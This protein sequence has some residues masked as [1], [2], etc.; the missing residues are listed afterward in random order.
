MALDVSRVRRLLRSFDFSRLFAEELG[1]DRYTSSLSVTVDGRD[2]SLEAVAEK[3]GL[4]AFECQSPAEDGVP[5]YAVRRKI[6]RQV[7]KS[8]HEHILIFTDAGRTTQTWQW[9]K[10]EPGRPAQC[11]EHTYY[12]GQ[13]GDSLIQK[14][15]A[16]Q[17]LFEEEE[18]LTVVDVAG[19]TRAAFDVDRV[20]RRFY[21]RFKTEHA[22]FLKFIKGIPSNDD[23]EWYASLM[24]NR[25][26]FI[27][28][29]QKK[30]FLD[31]DRDYLRNRLRRMRQT[32]GNDKFLSFYRHFLLRLFHEGLGSRNRNAE[33][34]ELLGNV[35]FLNGGLFDV[36][37]LE[38]HNP[39]IAIPD[40]AFERLFDFF[41]AYQWH[42]DERPL[43]KDDEINP[44]VLGYIFEKYVNQKQ[45]GAYYTKEDIT[46]YIAKNTII[47]FL[48]DAAEKRCPIAF[49]P[50]S[51]VWQLLRD[52]PDR[53]IYAAVRK[54]VIDADGKLIPLPD[55]IAAGVSDVSKRTGWN[56]PA[57]ADY[58]LPTETWREHVARRNRCLEIREKLRAGEV[59]SINDLVTLNLDI[60]QFAQDAIENCEGP[61]LLRAFYHSIA[62]RMPRKSNET[63]EPGISVLDPTCGSGAFL[64]AALNI[65]EPLYEACLSRMQA[66]V[67]E[68]EESRPLTMEEQIRKIIADRESATVELKSTLVGDGPK[69]QQKTIATL[70]A[71]ANTKGGILLIGVEDD[72]TVCGLAHDYKALEKQ[73]NRDGFE[74]CLMNMLTDRLGR[75]ASSLVDVVFGQLGGCEVCRV[76]VQPSPTEVYFRDGGS[77]DLFIRAGNSTRK[78]KTSEAVK[79][80]Q[81]RFEGQVPPE[82]T[83]QAVATRRPAAKFQDFRDVLARVA[84]H[85]NQRYFI[86]KSIIIGNLFGVDIMEEAVEICK[87]RLFLKL[88]AQVERVGQIEPLPDIDFNIRA[89]NT[90]VGFTSLGEIEHAMT[91]DARGNMRFVTS[92]DQAALETIRERADIANRAYQQFR[93]QQTELG[94]AV[95]PEDKQ[96]LRRRLTELGEE[97]DEYMACQYGID[98]ADET[99]FEN[100]RKSHQPFHWL[101][102]FYGAMNDGGFDIVIGNPPWIE[103]ASV[104]RV[105]TVRH[106]RTEGCGNLHAL[107]TERSLQLRGPKGRMSFIVQLPLVSSTRMVSVRNVLR[108][109]ST[110]L[111]VVPFDDRPGKLF[112]GLQHCRAV[113]FLTEALNSSP[114]RLVATTRYQRWYTQV[115]KHVFPLIEF[116]EL[117]GQ[118]I[119]PALFPKYASGVEE[120][121]FRKV[122][123]RADITVGE[124]VRRVETPHYIFYQEATQYWVKATIG[125]PYYAKNGVVGPPAH[126]RYLYFSNNR[127]ANAVCA[128]LH[129]SL[130]YAYFVAY[131][132]CF[133]LSQ[134]LATGFPI[135]SSLLDEE[136]LEALN[137][138]LMK[139]LRKNAQK[140]VI[141][142]REG[143]EIC[144]AEFFA[145]K[146]KEILDDID[147]RLGRHYGFN[148]D[149]LDLIVNYDIKFRMGQDS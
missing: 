116:A 112:D 146:S 113:I 79:Y 103:Y 15:E 72:G 68:S 71:M 11:R 147:N 8:V 31:G 91:V 126:G 120:Q 67:Q 74:L 9:V 138:A 6:E 108:E 130:F 132:D 2:Y 75:S 56:R 93:R 1:W 121:L 35:P 135:P 48:F 60:R 86:L 61:D 65:L 115:R 20:T 117:R 59:H 81:Q 140:Q 30:G 53:Y 118:P 58:A 129:S 137:N 50:D 78:L 23:R 34:D 62:G 99:A 77:E 101:A 46:D 114:E 64:F 12:R 27:Y 119:Y 133:H 17:F 66:M 104:R 148:D 49:Q 128:L 70:A 4:V 80:H 63:M 88:V 69:A 14:L 51:A 32:K 10:R 109:R 83:P 144:Y 44:D 52:N 141:N 107:C 47:P 38:E 26:M 87:L 16:I 124:V 98:P 84:E 41:E 73:G 106:Y 139:D 57:A 13:P 24:L 110:S 19:R 125:L 39:E 33:L 145:W 96:E 18:S 40:T 3:R 25:L 43:R 89:G 29:I 45:M 143:D 131:G 102:E 149:E 92:E 36:H 94:G 100:W 5:P 76:V 7:T 111:Y 127:H 55:E 136:E 134:T 90:L 42:L 21:D 28:F 82:M 54:G 95:T 22:A 123:E 105:Y 122:K 97:L 85:P 142:T 37:E